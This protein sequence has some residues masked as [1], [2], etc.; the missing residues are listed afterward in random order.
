MKTLPGICSA[1]ALTALFTACGAGAPPPAE[2]TPAATA[3]E[4]APA[5]SEV[6]PTF[7]GE[8]LPLFQAR[9][10]TCHGKAGGLDLAGYGALMQGADGEQVVLP[11]DPDGSELIEYVDGRKEKRMPLNA[12]PLADGEIAILRNWIAAGA[13]N[14]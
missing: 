4:A 6:A 8:V 1:S 9:C 2:P 12:P 14:D 13:R 11:G 10:T 5:P 3:E 7:S